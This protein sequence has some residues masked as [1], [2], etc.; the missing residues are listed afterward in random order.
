MADE[1]ADLGIFIIITPGDRNQYL[2]SHEYTSIK[3]DTARWKEFVCIGVV[4]VCVLIKAWWGG[5]WEMVAYIFF[6]LL[7]F[8]YFYWKEKMTSVSHLQAR[9][10]N[11]YSS[12]QDF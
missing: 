9:I 10:Y 2:Y 1:A 6:P 12:L 5:E 3:G 4:C 8:S 7:T 11:R